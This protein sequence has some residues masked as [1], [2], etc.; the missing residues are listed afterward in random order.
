M[1]EIINKRIKNNFFLR[2]TYFTP[3]GITPLPA[4]VNGDGC[5]EL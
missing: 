3:W 4:Q 1:I 2:S 5:F